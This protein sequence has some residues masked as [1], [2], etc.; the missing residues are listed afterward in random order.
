MRDGK[1]I[2]LIRLGAARTLTRGGGEVGPPEL[3]FTPIKPVG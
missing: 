3:D 2:S 1:I